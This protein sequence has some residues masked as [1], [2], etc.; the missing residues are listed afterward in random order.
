MSHLIRLI[1]RILPPQPEARRIIGEIQVGHDPRP[2]AP[3]NC[4]RDGHI[5]VRG[6]CVYCQEEGS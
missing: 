1:D 4:E 3:W 2:D 5:L 6:E